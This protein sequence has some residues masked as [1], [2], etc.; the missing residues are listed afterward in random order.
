M[1][2]AL[3]MLGEPRAAEPFWLAGF[4]GHAVA[5]RR[6]SGGPVRPGRCSISLRP[7]AETFGLWPWLDDTQLAVT[8]IYADYADP[9]LPR[10]AARLD[11]QRDR[12]RRLC[13]GSFGQRGAACCDHDRAGDQSSDPGEADGARGIGAGVPGHRRSGRAADPTAG[14]RLHS[15]LG[16][17]GISPAHPR[18]GLSHRPAL[19]AC[20][21]PRR[22]G[23]GAGRHAG[24][25]A[26]RHPGFGLRAGRTA[27]SANIASCSSTA[28][29]I[30]GI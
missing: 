24:R 21:G 1:A 7:A 13:D 16:C 17:T 3:V 9:S 23:P 22:A 18:P 2:R 29:F 14:P 20:R 28:R 19:H 26:V 15:R 25:G 27:W 5:A 11:H 8:V 6:V 30:P 4:V 10:A 12:R